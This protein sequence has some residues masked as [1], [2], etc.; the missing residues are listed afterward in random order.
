MTREERMEVAVRGM[1]TTIDHMRYL[2]MLK[3]HV[4]ELGKSFDRAN[5]LYEKAMA[6]GMMDLA[7]NAINMMS[8]INEEVEKASKEMDRVVAEWDAEMTA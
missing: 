1:H 5:E 2:T 3:Q 7:E 6:V 4:D 8:Q